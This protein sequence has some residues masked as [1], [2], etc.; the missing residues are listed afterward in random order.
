MIRGKLDPK[1]LIDGSVDLAFIADLNDALDVA[2]EN[3]RRIEEAS[4]K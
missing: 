3:D 1:S 4:R 2:D